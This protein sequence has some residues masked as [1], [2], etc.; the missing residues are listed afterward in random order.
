MVARIL[1]VLLFRHYHHLVNH[2]H[3]PIAGLKNVKHLALALADD[4][5]DCARARDRL[6]VDREAVQEGRR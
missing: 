4:P 3:P 1:S 2:K 6:D 5:P